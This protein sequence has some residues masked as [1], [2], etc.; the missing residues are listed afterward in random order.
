MA[1]NSILDIKEILNEYSQDIQDGI[2]EAAV[3][4][5][6]LGVRKLIA[7]SP[8]NTGKYAKG[9]KVSKTKGNGFIECTIHNAKRWQLTH[10][11]EKPHALRN[12]RRSTPKEHIYPVEQF[13]IKDYEN[14]VERVIQNG[15]K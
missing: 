12:G 15:G 9:W 5:S 7:S 11:L 3:K 6:D 10:L 8:K 13:V 2:E 1:N 4:V 14:A